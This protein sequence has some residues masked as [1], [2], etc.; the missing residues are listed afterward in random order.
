MKKILLL[1][2]LTA[3]CLCAQAQV[4]EAWITM[5]DSLCPFLTEQQRLSMLQYAKAGLTDTIANQF[6]GKS[7]LDS[8]DLQHNYISAQITGNMQME[9]TTEDKIVAEEGDEAIAECVYR[10]RTTVCAPL[11]ST[12]TKWYNRLWEL[13]RSEK[14]PWD[15][16]RTEEDRMQH[17]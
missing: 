5:P 1:I 9:L 14:E 15:I 7:Y 16:E 3:S 8:V 17:F 11:C 2:W 6:E 12:I 10:I 4:A 13:I